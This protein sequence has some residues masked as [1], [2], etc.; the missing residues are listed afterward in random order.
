[1]I[2]NYF[3]LAEIGK[4]WMIADFTHETPTLS[5]Y[6]T[7]RKKPADYYI[8]VLSISA[9]SGTR[10]GHHNNKRNLVQKFK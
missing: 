10:T 8:T 2:M 9:I 5:T 7:K 3:R 6:L 4:K 1:M